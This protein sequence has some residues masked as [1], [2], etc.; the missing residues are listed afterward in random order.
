AA[1][2]LAL[3]LAG[4]YPDPETGER[5]AAAA[6]SVVIEDSLDGR[7]ADLVAALDLGPRLALVADEDTFVALGARVERALAPRFTVQRIVLGRE[8]HADS[9][10]VARLRQALDERTDAVVAV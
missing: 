2:A 9:A 1:D 4:Q 7:E 5:L 8:P 10:T 3:L 6:R